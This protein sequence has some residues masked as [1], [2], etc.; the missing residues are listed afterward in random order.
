MQSGAPSEAFISIE[1]TDEQRAQVADQTGRFMT[2]LIVNRMSLLAMAMAADADAMGADMGIVAPV[3]L[4]LTP[5]QR[6]LVE[7]AVSSPATRLVFDPDVVEIRFGEDWPSDAEPMPLGKR[8]LIVPHGATPPEAG[9][10]EP[11]LLSTSDEE[12]GVFG[13]GR[14]ASTR[15]A[16]RLVEKWLGGARSVA[17]VGTGSGIL[18]IMALKLGAATVFALDVE[19]AAVDGARQNFA[20]NGL[21][22]AATFAARELDST[23]DGP[24]DFVIAN[25][26]PNLLLRLAPTLAAITTPGGT[27]VVAGCVD[28]RIGHVVDR[29][30]AAGFDEVERRSRVGWSG[31]ALRR[32]D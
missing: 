16:A 9:D 20:L 24:F 7:S 6:E 25:L 13:T 22:A 1:L 21:G 23:V 27:L 11:L 10:R 3:H 15:I 14:H 18:G 17:D 31:S 2:S 29:L 30:E 32:T 12:G 5:E 8:F 4:L 19:E 28:N 26:F